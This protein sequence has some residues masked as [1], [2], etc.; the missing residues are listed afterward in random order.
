LLRCQNK[1]SPKH[2]VLTY[3]GYGAFGMRLIVVNI[4]IVALFAFG[5]SQN[6]SASTGSPQ[7]EPKIFIPT[8]ISEQAQKIL[9]NLTMNVPSFSTPDPDDREGWTKLNQYA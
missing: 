8:T 5:I 4:F 6:S 3:A 1:A 9:K 7:N 2:S